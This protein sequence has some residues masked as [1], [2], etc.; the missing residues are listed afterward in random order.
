[1]VRTGMKLLMP[2]GLIIVL[3]ML[4]ALAL[5]GDYKGKTLLAQSDW[6]EEAK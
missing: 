5:V 4:L 3:C 6:F 1:M 2:S